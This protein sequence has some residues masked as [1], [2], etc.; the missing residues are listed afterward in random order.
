M[1]HGNEVL[2]EILPST[3]VLNLLNEIDPDAIVW[4]T[5]SHYY[6]ASEII[7]LIKVKDDAGVQFVHDLMR[8]ARDVLEIRA[9]RCSR[10]SKQA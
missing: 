5:M 8:T 7:E 10:S 2:T 3:F 4:R 1:S 9:T 6:T